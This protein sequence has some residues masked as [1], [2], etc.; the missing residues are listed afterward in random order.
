MEDDITIEREAAIAAAR[1]AGRLIQAGFGGR[2]R[3]QPKRNAIDLVT[4][5][6]QQAE[7]LI[8]SMLQQVFPSYGFLTEESPAATGAT[9]RYW[10]IDPLDGTTN[11]AHGYPLVAVSIALAWEDN[12]VLGVVY[13]PIADELFVAEKGQGATLN[14]RPIHVSNTASLANS[15]LASGFPYYAWERDD[16][17]TTEWKH[18]LKRVVSL[19]SDGTAALDLCHVACGRLDGYWELDLDPWDMAA[20]SLIVQEAGGRVTDLSGNLFNPYGRSILASNGRLHQEMLEVLQQ[21][22]CGRGL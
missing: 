8:V 9:E 3:T 22:R 20:G 14:G 4:Q 16:D 21:A 17:N 6:D 12:I 5:T 15:L 19:R 18:F 11:Y 2:H 1:A 10:L 13:N 7:A